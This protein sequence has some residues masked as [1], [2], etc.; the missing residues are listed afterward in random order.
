M[1]IRS[2]PRASRFPVRRLALLIS[3][4]SLCLI[5]PFIQADD[6]VP[7]PVTPPAS[8]DAAAMTL[9]TVSVIGQGETRQV[10]RVTQKD[11]KAYSAGTSPMKIL[12]RLPGVNFQSGDPLGREEG[13]QRISLRGF[14]M[15]HLGYT[16]DGVTL[17]NMS[18][19]NFNGLSITRAIIAENIAASEVAPGIGSLGTASNSDLGGTLQFTSSNP[20][21]AFGARLSQTLGSYDTSRTFMRVDTGEYNGLSAYVSGEKYDADAW[22][23]H[24]N[25]QKSDAVNAKI[26][27][28]FGDNRVSFFHSTSSHDEAN[29]PSLSPS[30]I[31]RLGY[32]WSYYTPDWTRAV[33]AANGIYTGGVTSAGDA[34]YNASSLRDDELDILNGNFSLTDDLVLDATVYHHHDSG[35][36]NSYYPFVYTS[37]A[38]TVPSNAIR[39]TVYGIDR[40][41]F[42]SSLTY[43]LGQHEIQAG[44]WIQSNKNDIARYL[45]DTTNATPQNHIVK[46]NGL[47]LAATVLDQSYNDLTRQFYLRDTY[48]LL[49]DRLKL[50]FGAKN[51]VTTSTAKG[52]GG[53]YA[54]GSLEARDRFL[55]QVG[56]TYKLNDSDE[57]FTSYSENMAAFPSGGYSPFFTTQ[58]AVDAQNGFKDLKPE[59]SKTVELGL[60]R[61]TKLYSA[62]AAV[63]N[64]RFDNRLVA[65]TNCTGIVICQNGVANV[66]SVTSRGLELSLGLTPNENWRWSNSMSYNHSTYDDDYASGGSTVQVKGKTVVDTPKLMYSSSLDWNWEHWNA[67]LQGNYISK[68]YYTYTNDSSVSGYWLANANLGYDCGKLGALKDTTVS[69]NMVNL[70]DKRYISTL[71]TDASA[72]ADPSGNLQI[73][74]VGTPRSAFV[75]LGVK[76]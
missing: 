45:F 59:T 14:D 67:G 46:T 69:L 66:G 62:S 15:H 1:S 49:D 19:G 41:G 38:T 23:G 60:R 58:T 7:A 53:G 70:F 25:P 16:L 26:N 50:E 75:T 17:G 10:Q 2:I 42:Q 27:Y 51:T 5:S 71:N 43:F 64:T 34:T 21:K 12:Q 55:P 35:R 36:G 39:S 68:R 47:P 8:D 33:N 61:S 63:Y 3:L 48:T 13:G 54:S 20:D 29:L 31:Q 44:F 6:N 37:G 56:A 65:I 24:N 40:T 57:V 11:V 9:G 30:I 18:F 32:N 76:L 52:K 72:A 4:N 22:K 73:L 28:N 74:Q